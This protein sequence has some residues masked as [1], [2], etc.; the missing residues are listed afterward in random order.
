MSLL[1]PPNPWYECVKVGHTSTGVCVPYSFWMVVRGL[2]HSMTTRAVR[3]DL[4]FFILKP[5]D[6]QF[7]LSFSTAPCTPP[8]SYSPGLPPQCSPSLITHNILFKGKHLLEFKRPF[9]TFKNLVTKKPGSNQPCKS[10]HCKYNKRVWIG[11]EGMIGFRH[12]TR[13]NFNSVQCPLK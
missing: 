1:Y 3:P 8:M 2:L 12:H 11:L 13:K 4:R 7:L 9:Y 6:W 5:E 10:L